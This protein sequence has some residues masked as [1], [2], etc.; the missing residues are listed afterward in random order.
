MEWIFSKMNMV[1][2]LR[3]DKENEVDQE[4]IAVY[5]KGLGKV[6]YV[7]NSPYTVLGQSISAGRMYDKIGKKAK[8]R[9]RFVLEKG[10][11][12][13][14]RKEGIGVGKTTS[15]FLCSVAI[16]ENPCIMVYI[17]ESCKKCIAPGLYRFKI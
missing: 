13:C 1:V 3:K 8:G 6:G 16:F 15:I 5:V 14:I 7:A 12:L 9:V 11:R 2:T 10:R 17:V 4:A